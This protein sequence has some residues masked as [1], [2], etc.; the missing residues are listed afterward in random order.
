MTPRVVVVYGLGACGPFDVVTACDEDVEPCF[1]FDSRDPH[2]ADAGPLL[3]EIGFAVDLAETSLERAAAELD[4]YGV[5][6]IVTF[7]EEMLRPAGALAE[8]LELPFHDR[9]ALERLTDKHAQRRALLAAGIPCPRFVPVESADEAREALAE[10]GLPAVLKPIRGAGSVDTYELREPAAVEAAVRAT[11]NGSSERAFLVEELLVGAPHPGL[12]WLGDYVSVESVVY[13]GGYR[14]FSICDKLPLA[15]PFRE[16]GNVIP[17]ALPDELQAEVA[18]LTDRAL[19]A[20]GVGDGVTQTE[21]KL[22][23]EGPRVLEVNG[24]A[25]GWVPRILEQ[26][27]ELRPA[28]IAIDVAL[29]RPPRL[30]T[31]VTGVSLQVMSPSPKGAV[32]V[33]TPA[34]VEEL[35]RIPGVYAVDQNAFPG[36]P[37]D[38]RSGTRGRICTIWAKAATFDEAERIVGE[39]DE[40]VGRTASF[41]YASEVGSSQVTLSATQTSSLA[42]LSR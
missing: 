31:T 28:R 6:G 27:S 36:M 19:A 13:D 11:W 37:V 8:L 16:A 41:D 14:H 24:R 5:D 1:V 30:D 10:I 21:I 17:S 42:E 32:A 29:G 20:C 4:E 35:R 18:A 33:V 15:P 38:W 12:S 39:I 7:S 34:D 2:G 9:R 25:G 26:I 3:G 23:P 22:T 40:V